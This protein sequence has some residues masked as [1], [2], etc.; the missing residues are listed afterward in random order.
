MNELST[1]VIGANRAGP[2]HVA[3][4]LDGIGKNFSPEI[5][6][7]TFNLYVPIHEKIEWSGIRVEKDL[8]YGADAERNLLDL[9]APE[10]GAGMPTVIFFH[11]GGFVQG[12]K[13]RSGSPLIYSN[14]GNYFASQGIIGLNA[15]Y[16]LA[17]EHKWPSGA[18]DVGTAIAWARAN[19]AE[20][21]GDPDR[22]FVMGESAGAG[23]VASYVFRPDLHLPGG[24]GFAGAVLLSGVYSINAEKTAPNHVAY[25]GDD[26]SKY[27]ERQ[28][29]GNIGYSDFPLF[30][31]VSEYDVPLFEVQLLKL[32]SEVTERN[33][34]APRFKQLM[35]HNHVS[36][37]YSFGTEDTSVS[38]DV[39]DFV[40]GA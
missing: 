21:G 24:P 19:V 29:L 33:G 12:H 16:R 20:Y 35:G 7:E 10:S 4:K 26:K 37:V 18:E 39:A 25:Y 13:N 40:L 32:V 17:P 11:G 8:A 9:H 31:S 15:T 30:V 38:G 28:V 14:V 22:V 6:E 23:H 3:A 1:P 36:Q 34:R 5:I 2:A 27:S